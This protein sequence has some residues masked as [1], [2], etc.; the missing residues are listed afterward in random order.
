MKDEFELVSGQGWRRF[1]RNRSAVVSLILL[2]GIFLLCVCTVG[3]SSKEYSKQQLEFNRHPPQWFSSGEESDG[4]VA[5]FGYDILGRSIFWRCLFGGIVSLGI[6]LAAATISVVIGTAWGAI[7][8][9]YGGRVDSVMM[10]VV[11]VLYG[12]PYILLVILFK[13]G[14]EGILVKWF[15]PGH[16]EM[17]NIVILFVAIGGGGVG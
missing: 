7:A 5:L 14:F 4:G 8:G 17:A 9:W 13:V 2:S 3:I 11:D 1:C 12:L 16:E 10:R 15:G 6:G